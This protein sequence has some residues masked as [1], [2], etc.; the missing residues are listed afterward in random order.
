MF[1]FLK[2]I[3]SV[4]TWRII[5]RKV[6]ANLDGFNYTKLVPA[7]RVCEK[8]YEMEQLVTDGLTTFWEKVDIEPAEVKEFI[9]KVVKKEKG[10]L[11]IQTNI[12]R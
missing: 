12:R 6:N 1:K 10:K 9:K 3:F 2:N 4:H 8:C 7:Y 11:V 5:Y